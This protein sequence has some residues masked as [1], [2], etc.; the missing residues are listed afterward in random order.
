M[1]IPED[2]I[3]GESALDDFGAVVLMTLPKSRVQDHLKKRR[4]VVFL[5]DRTMFPY[6][7]HVT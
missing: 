2:A 3:K 4:I 7:A 1:W 6:I 5:S